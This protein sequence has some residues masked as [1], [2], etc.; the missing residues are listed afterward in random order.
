MISATDEFCRRHTDFSGHR[1]TCF[2]NQIV[3][4]KGFHDSPEY[5][6]QILRSIRSWSFPI[7]I[8]YFDWESYFYRFQKGYE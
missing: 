1:H 2:G 5:W 4:P 8:N 7:I 3:T 6:N